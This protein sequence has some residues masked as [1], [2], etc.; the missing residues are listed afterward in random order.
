MIVGF[1]N[2]VA[3]LYYFVFNC[4]I[5]HKCFSFNM[6]PPYTHTYTPSLH[7]PHTSTHTLS[8]TQSQCLQMRTVRVCVAHLT[9]VFAVRTEG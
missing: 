7:T 1:D 3:G 4:D 2:R 9:G 8:H 5:E 6:P